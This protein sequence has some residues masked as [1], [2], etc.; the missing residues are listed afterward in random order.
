MN[1]SVLRPATLAIVVLLYLSLAGPAT[2][3]IALNDNFNDN[4]LDAALWAVRTDLPSGKATYASVTEESGHI[5]LKDRGHLNTVSQFDPTATGGVWISGEWTFN[6]LGGVDSMQILT[7][8]DGAPTAG[9]GETLNGIEFQYWTNGTQ[10]NIVSRGGSLSVGANAK[11]GSLAVAQGDTFRFDA[12]DDGTDLYFTMTEV[13]APT[14]TASVQSSVVTDSFAQDLIAFHNREQSGSSHIAFLDNVVVRDNI[15]VADNFSDGTI[16]GKW[17]ID[18]SARGGTAVT[19]SGGRIDL[20]QRGYLK[21]AQQFDPADPLG[22]RVTGQWQ[23][24]NLDDMLQI[25]TRTDGTG[26]GGCCH[27]LANGIQ[28]YIFPGVNQFRLR[29]K[30]GGDLANGDGSVGFITTGMFYDFEMIDD[31]TNVTF[32]ITDPDNPANTATLS[33]VNSFDNATN[34]VI[35]H[36][37]ENQND[38]FLDNIVIEGLGAAAVPEPSTF[39]LSAFAL[40]GLGW[41]GRRRKRAA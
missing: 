18:T 31:G 8:S 41:Y 16:A 10:P 6:A 30:G 17:T 21:T 2:A 1:G 24:S 22:L 27:E 36:N 40:L 20:D 14:S 39:V 34:L 32:T 28:A 23:F 35:F 29:Q 19:E 9:S 25:T 5:T 26:D 13:G 33:G 7:R 3:S 12:I 38:A 15:Y 37:R 11:T 4:S